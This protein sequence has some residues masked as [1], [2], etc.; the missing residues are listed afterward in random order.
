MYY[1]FFGLSA[2]PFELTP[3]PRFLYLTPQ[4]QEALSTLEY[5]IRF[6][7][8][9]TVLT[10]EAGLGKTALIHAALAACEQRVPRPHVIFLK[11]PALTRAEFFETVARACDL[12][13]AAGI[14]KPALLARLEGSL[15]GGAGEGPI[16]LIADEAHV[17]PLDL[18]EEIRLLSNIETATEKL[19]SIVLAGQPE[20]ADRLNESAL[21]QLKQ[22]VALRCELSPFTA[23][24]TAGYILTRLRAAGSANPGALFSAEA[25]ALI[26]QKSRGIPRLINVICDNALVT[27]FATGLP[28]VEA[29]IIRD[30]ARDFDLDAPRTSRE[31]AQPAGVETP[32]RADLASRPGAPA[33]AAATGA[34]R[35]AVPGAPALFGAV[36]RNRMSFLAR[37]FSR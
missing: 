25:V 12:P 22:R 33:L 26:H 34:M 31:R 7:K 6:R 2:A 10:G 27:A 32:S 24:D 9:L 1:A 3:N 15:E 4:H 5:A 17:M 19:V 37:V 8:G 30:V 13:D 20:L 36:T 11:N 18:L 21:R 28:S 16:V 35:A 23:Q 29:Q 14:S